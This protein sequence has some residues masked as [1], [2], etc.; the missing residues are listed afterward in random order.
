MGKAILFKQF[1]DAIKIKSRHNFNTVN[2]LNNIILEIKDNQ[3]N[4]SEKQEI[5][6]NKFESKLNRLE[7]KVVVNKLNDTSLIHKNE[8]LN[9]V[10][11]LDT[12]VIKPF[13]NTINKINETDLPAILE[14]IQ[15]I[16]T[17]DLKPVLDAI[18][19][20][21]KTDVDGILAAISNV[22]TVDDITSAV[23]QITDTAVN[24]LTDRIIGNEYFATPG[25]KLLPDLI[26]DLHTDTNAGFE[27]TNNK[28]DAL[29]GA[30]NNINCA[31]PPVLSEFEQAVNNYE[32]KMAEFIGTYGVID[33]DEMDVLDPLSADATDKL[34]ALGLIDP[35]NDM[36]VVK[37]RFH[38]LKDFAEQY[39]DAS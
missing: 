2:N 3:S 15:S 23:D 22:P 39:M 9:T 13:I 28:L 5:K 38:S 30:I 26:G 25:R 18:K 1:K 10:A 8:I 12:S 31:E 19:A 24:E 35:G 6:L 27:A 21:P 34:D 32:S 20:I 4:L 11:D 7:N 29:T 33:S 37:I 16:P 36:Y 14:A 17:T